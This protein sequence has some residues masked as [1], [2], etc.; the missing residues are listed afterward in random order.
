MPFPI[1]V[2]QKRKQG[3]KA[4]IW[5]RLADSNFNADIRYTNKKSF[6]QKIR[7]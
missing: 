3:A 2:V 7:N 6:D 1:K 5:T 4:A